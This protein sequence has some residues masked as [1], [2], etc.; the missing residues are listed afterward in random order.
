MGHSKNARL[1]TNYV[2][3]LLTRTMPDALHCVHTHR[4]ALGDDDNFTESERISA[5]GDVA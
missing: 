3:H 1:A 2:S 5:I 4:N